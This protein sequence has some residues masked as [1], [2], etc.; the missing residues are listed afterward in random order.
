MVVLIPVRDTYSVKILQEFPRV[1]GV[2]CPL[3]FILDNLEVRIHLIDAEYLHID[4]TPGR[5]FALI[6]QH[7]GVSV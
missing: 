2:V 5:A 3:V 4:F 6:Y 7:R 1:A